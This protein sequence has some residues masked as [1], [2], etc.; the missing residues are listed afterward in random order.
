MIMTEQGVIKM[1]KVIANPQESR[2]F[3][4]GREGTAVLSYD[5]I[6]ACSFC[7]GYQLT[8]KEGK[9]FIPILKQDMRYPERGWKSKEKRRREDNL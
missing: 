5:K 4:C 7:G 2:C 1:A 8:D 3:A 6:P 9:E